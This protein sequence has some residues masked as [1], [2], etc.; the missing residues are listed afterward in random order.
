M[1]IDCP[2]CAPRPDDTDHWIKVATLP[3]ATLLG[4]VVP[5]LHVHLVPRYRTDPRWG[6]PSYTTA[7]AEMPVTRLTEVEYRQ[8]AEDIREALIDEDAHHSG[9]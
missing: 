4:N 7:Q 2:L 1:G 6:G 9:R 5:H 3:T 8:I